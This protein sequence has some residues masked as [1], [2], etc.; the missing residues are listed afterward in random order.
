MDQGICFGNIVV[1]CNDEQKLCRFYKQLLGWEKRE[2]YGHPAVRSENGL[3]F[4]FIE[5]EEYVS[6]IWPDQ[7]NKQQKQMH[8]DFQVED[9]AIAVQRAETLGAVKAK[10]QFGGDHFVTM[11]DPA[12]H[13]FCL[14]AKA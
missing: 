13:P 14:C 2:M 8:F 1:D 12:G 6:P 3:V 4:L 11:I 10:S 7:L 5:D 9:V